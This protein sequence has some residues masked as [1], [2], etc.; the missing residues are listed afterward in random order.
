[1]AGH[2]HYLCLSELFGKAFLMYELDLEARRVQGGKSAK[3]FLPG[4]GTQ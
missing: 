3:A 1:M 4:V 2:L